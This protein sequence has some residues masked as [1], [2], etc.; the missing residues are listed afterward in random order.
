MASKENPK[1]AP[2]DSPKPGQNVFVLIDG[3]KSGPHYFVQA[4]DGKAELQGLKDPVP[5]G[6]LLSK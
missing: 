6:D 4:V 1:P 3:K 5:V 2:S